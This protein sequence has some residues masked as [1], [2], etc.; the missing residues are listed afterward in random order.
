MNEEGMILGCENK[1][2]FEVTGF[3]IHGHTHN[4]N[5]DYYAMKSEDQMKW[6]SDHPEFI[7]VP[8]IT[9]YSFNVSIEVIDYKPIPFTDIVEKMNQK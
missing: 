6:K 5:A 4:S 1:L 2:D 9:H 7:T 8:D 3:Q